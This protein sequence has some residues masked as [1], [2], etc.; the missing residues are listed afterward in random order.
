MPEIAE[1]ELSGNSVTE[2]R[3]FWV[4]REVK[5]IGR[6]EDGQRLGWRKCCGAF[7]I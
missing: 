2:E 6:G 5:R 1:E 4:Y 3:C 7:D